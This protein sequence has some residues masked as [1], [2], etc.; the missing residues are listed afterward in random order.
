MIAVA[1][2]AA[3][4]AGLLLLGAQAVALAPK[5]SSRSSSR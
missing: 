5:R 2:A 3:V 1:G 4:I